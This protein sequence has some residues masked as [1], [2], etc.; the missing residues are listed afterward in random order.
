MDGFRLTINYVRII[1]KALGRGEKIILDEEFKIREKL[2]PK[3]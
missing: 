1:E 2:K 3:V